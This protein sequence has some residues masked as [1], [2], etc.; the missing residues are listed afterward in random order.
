M[1]HSRCDKSGGWSWHGETTPQN[2]VIIYIIYII[3]EVTFYKLSYYYYIYIYVTLIYILFTIV[4]FSA[5]QKT[6]TMVLIKDN[7]YFDPE[8]T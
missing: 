6:R 3:I 7:G 2:G 4:L 1:R 8:K 5:K